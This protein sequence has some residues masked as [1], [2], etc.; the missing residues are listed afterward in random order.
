MNKLPQHNTIGNTLVL[1]MLSYSSKVTLEIDYPCAF[2]KGSQKAL[3]CFHL[4]LTPMH[5]NAV[6]VGDATCSF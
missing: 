2:V 4:M 1:T 5:M 6:L 3:Y